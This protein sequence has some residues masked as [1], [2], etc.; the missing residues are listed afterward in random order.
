MFAARGF[1]ASLCCSCVFVCCHSLL[2]FSLARV[3][4]RLTLAAYQSLNYTSLIARDFSE[5]TSLG[6]W[7]V[8]DHDSRE[9]IRGELRAAS[10]ALFTDD[11]ALRG[12]EDILVEAVHKRHERLKAGMPSNLSAHTPFHALDHSS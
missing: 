11:G 6:V 5:Y 12:W 7:L 4:R 9:R 1:A 2:T 10:P 3:C 8:S